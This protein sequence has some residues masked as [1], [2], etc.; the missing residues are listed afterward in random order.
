MKAGLLVVLLLPAALSAPSGSSAGWQPAAAGSG[1][2]KAKVMPAAAGAAPSG[3]AASHDV[4]VSWT[5]MQFADGGNVPGYVV[6]RYDAITGAAQTVLSGCSGT[7]AATSCVEHSVPAGSW[8]Y[9]MTPAAGT[10]RGVE[11]PES[12]TV[13]VLI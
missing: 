12:A 9:T 8:K 6:T 13:I 7:V 11:S 2:S 1:A 5:A 10:W 4:T 3:S